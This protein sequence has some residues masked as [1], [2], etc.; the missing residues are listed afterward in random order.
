LT[1]YLR[2]LDISVPLAPACDLGSCSIAGHPNGVTVAGSR[3]YVAAGDAGLATVDV[4][5]PALPSVLDGIIDTPGSANGV[6]VSGAYAYVAD[7]NSGLQILDVSSP[8]AAIVGSGATDG[9][10]W[11][12]DVAGDYAYVASGDAGLEV[13]DVSDRASPTKVAGLALSGSAHSIALKDTYA[14][15]SVGGRGVVVVDVADPLHPAVVTSCGTP[16][17]PGPS[18]LAIE[19]GYAYV[20]DAESGLVIVDIV[21]PYVALAALESPAMGQRLAITAP[22]D[23]SGVGYIAAGLAGLQIVQVSDSED[24]DNPSLV[25]TNRTL[26]E[27]NDVALYKS[28]SGVDCAYVTDASGR[29]SVLNAANPTNP[30]TVG[31]VTTSG[32]ALGVAATQIGASSY[33]LVAGGYDGLS[34]V[35]TSVVSSPT[36]RTVTDTPGWCSGV[37]AAT[38]AGDPF[39]LVA[40]GDAGLRLLDLS[41][42][43]TPAVTV[44]SEGFEASL[45]GW[46]EGGT[47][48]WYT[49]APRR[50]THDVRLRRDG[51][52]SRTVSTVGY[53]R[54]SVSFYLG[55]AVDADGEYV[56][57][58]WSDGTTWNE[59]A[60][61]DNGDT[62]DDGQ[63]H[64]Y[65]V[66][67]PSSADEN[68]I[69]ALRFSVSG[70]A[71]DDYGYV[72]DILLHSE[73][74]SQPNE[75][76]FYNTPGQAR[77]VA[78]SGSYALVADGEAGLRVIDVSS[79]GSPVEL[80]HLDLDG[81][82]EAVT[83]YGGNVAAVAD[84]GSGLVLVNFSTPSAPFEVAYYHT[85][86]WAT[87][88]KVL[89]DHAWVADT[90]W[91][92]TILKLW[93]SF[94]DVLFGNWAFFEIEDAVENGITVGYLDG[95]YHPEITCSRD[96]MCVFIARAMNWVQSN[97]P[98]NTEGDQFMDVPAG[99]WAGKAIKAC[100]GTNADDIVVVEGYTDNFFRP[101]RTVQRDDMCVFIARAN[102]WI[103]NTRTTVDTP[104]DTA[105][106]LFPDVLANYWCGTAI[107]ACMVHDVV[108]GY[109]DGTYL[110]Y[111]PVTRDQM[112]VFIWRAFLR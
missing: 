66:E 71:L 60:R 45:S 65:T 69:F 39:A 67:L 101:T 63:L 59:L 75:V 23:G 41:P 5:N 26:G 31:S 64:Y 20:A 83:T 48:E 17:V 85:P 111:M 49:G 19:G 36:E 6:V 34:T 84:G 112:A 89:N 24:A 14:F 76:G 7:G 32:S 37:A 33:A 87:D 93:N 4:S 70:D 42:V 52:I 109:P 55:A 78:V 68:P 72:D 99:H 57:A 27:V 21:S 35:S 47:V 9:Y 103:P 105:P 53:G 73:S 108:R 80:G 43:G 22:S 81:T 40:D 30:Y 62:N 58:E 1:G 88:V 56:L 11:D 90:G 86:G 28:L 10:C 82:A 106:E 104:M 16:S 44:F 46:T 110:P 102:G 13:F 91:G 2:V 94:R 38:L 25:R 100:T 107:Q 97:E 77:G 74:S 15:V 96:Q 95:K 50:G 54:L 61:I 98:M 29:L 18:D 79:P 51:S 12:V 8:T 92:L 3:A